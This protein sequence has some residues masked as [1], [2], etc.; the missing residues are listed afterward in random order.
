MISLITPTDGQVSDSIDSNNE[1]VQRILNNLQANI[2]IPHGRDQA[3]LL[4][5]RFT[6]DKDKVK[7][8]I[9]TYAQNPQYV[10]S[11]AKQLED[12]ERR[13][14]SK[15]NNEV[16]IYTGG[17]LGCFFL[18]AKGYKELGYEKELGKFQEDSFINGMKS[19][20]NYYF[21]PQDEWLTI[22]NKDPLPKDWQI[23]YRDEIHAMLLLAQA[24]DEGDL[25]ETTVQPLKA[26]LE[27]KGIV[28]KNVWVESGRRLSNKNGKEIEPFG[29]RDGISNP[30][31]FSEKTKVNPKGIFDFLSAKELVLVLDPLAEEDPEHC[32]GS[33]LVFRK[34]EQD[35]TAFNTRIETLA[36]QATKEALKRSGA[37]IIGRFRDG[38]P[39]TKFDKPQGPTGDTIEFDFDGDDGRR[40]PLHAHIRKANPRDGRHIRIVRR[41]IPYNEIEND[42]GSGVGLLFMCYQ[43]NIHNQ[44]ELIQRVWVDNRNH[45]I[46]GTGVDRLIGQE[47]SQE[48]NLK[49]PIT[50]QGGEYFFAPSLSFLRNLK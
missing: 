6:G 37:E 8:W 29:Y 36:T 21:K 19:R 23:S 28:E 45:P 20:S 32:Y 24:S 39:R 34:L 3:Y 2:L 48:I 13:R 18:S 11:A 35:K 17:L 31:F 49:Y 14:I 15:E 16:P 47:W 9:R 43:R 41:G 50:L 42:T 7:E 1:E 46:I 12:V 30:L 10:T 26:D 40:C 38:T 33:Y 22:T 4:F 5:L 44:F 27:N 25:N